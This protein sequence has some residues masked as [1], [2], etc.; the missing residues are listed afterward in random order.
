MGSRG[1][2]I[3]VDALMTVVG[4]L[5]EVELDRLPDVALLEL[6][7]ALGPALNAVQAQL[8]RVVGAIHGR[9]AARADGFGST[10]A[11]LTA[12]L[13]TA[14]AGK[15][16]RAARALAVSPQ[17]AAAY[18]RGQIGL[19]H[20]DQVAAVVDDIPAPLLAAGVDKLFAEQAT[21]LTPK[22][23]RRAAERIRDHF[24]PDAAD[25]RHRNQFDRRWLSVAQTYQGSV[26]VKGMLD[27]EAGELLINTLN[28]LMPPPQPSDSRTA[29]QRRA[30]A[31]TDLCRLGATSAPQ[32][33]GEKPHVTVTVDLATLRSAL[34]GATVTTSAGAMLGNS[35]GA[36]AR[37][38]P[39]LGSG[40]PIGP[41]VARRL[42]CDATIIPMVLGSR[43]EPLDIGRATRLIP[44]AIRRA[45]TT[46]D[47]RCRFP[48]CD[49]SPQWTDGHHLHPW[50]DGG[51]TSLRNLILLC[52]SHHG[53]V[54]EGNFTIRLDQDTGVVRA[55][56]PDGRPLDM[57]SRPRSELP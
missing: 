17:V 7:R 43:S 42:A 36:R 35:D 44:A 21:Q 53:L 24:D 2:L 20:V 8:T 50:A 39:A 6:S 1:A 19:D 27:P 34:A 33:G 15:H 32:A 10:Q 47:G 31:L 51:P 14:D 41:E 3:A 18:G 30:D 45:L 56:Y 38:G 26:S 52:R 49:R 46:R 5:G 9:G 13:R 23:F 28:A 25:R 40:A 57:I 16:V 54:H 48:G 37:R 22:L 29:P 55:F 11:W 12:R 4:R